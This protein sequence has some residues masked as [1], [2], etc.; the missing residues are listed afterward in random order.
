M[1]L[2]FDQSAYRNLLAEV[3]PKVI[4]TEEEYERTLAQDLRKDTRYR[5]GS[6]KLH[7]NRRMF[8]FLN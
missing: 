6:N 4:E 1:T 3:A 8:E 2:T 7:T 5:V